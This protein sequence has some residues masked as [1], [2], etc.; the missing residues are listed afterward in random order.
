M[1]IYTAGHSTSSLEEFVALL[2]ENGVEVVCDVR[3][4]P[5]SRLPHFD[6]MPIEQAIEAAGMR[7]RFVGD[8]LGGVPRDRSVASRW[9]QGHLDPVIIDHLRSTDD[10]TDGVAELAKLVRGGTSVCVICS[11]ADP[12]ECHRKAVALDVAEAA[13]DAAI[14]HLAVNRQAPKEVGVQEVLL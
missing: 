9:R 13:G 14:I 12:N 2:Q 5:R 8:R 3:S 11:E 10:W 1:S 6:R 7:Y 4:K